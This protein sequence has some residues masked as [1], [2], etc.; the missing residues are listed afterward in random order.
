MHQVAYWS[1]IGPGPSFLITSAFD[2]IT[3][4]TTTTQTGREFFGLF[5][6]DSKFT[7]HTRIAQVTD[8]QIDFQFIRMDDTTVS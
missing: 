8:A 1:S 3:D 4:K 6:G 5:L 2:P 7:P